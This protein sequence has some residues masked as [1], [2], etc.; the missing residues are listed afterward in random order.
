MNVVR[1]NDTPLDDR[2][3]IVD[4]YTQKFTVVLRSMTPIGPETLKDLIQKRYEV[5][6]ITKDDI[7]AYVT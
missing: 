7:T 1:L 6:N 5:T 3:S 4:H 2:V